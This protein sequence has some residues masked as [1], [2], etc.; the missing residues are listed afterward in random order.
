MQC[1]AY[2]VYGLGGARIPTPL[3]APTRRPAPPRSRNPR[4]ATCRE[5]FALLSASH[6]LMPSQLMGDLRKKEGVAA[7]KEKQRRNPRGVPTFEVRRAHGTAGSRFW[8]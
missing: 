4:G 3:T 7:L 1:G 5:A 6:P 8:M 2:A